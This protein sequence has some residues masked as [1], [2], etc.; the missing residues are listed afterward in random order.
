[1]AETKAVCGG[2]LIGEGLKM[3]GKVLSATG[4]GGEVVEFNV[5]WD[6]VTLY[7]DKSAYLLYI[8]NSEIED[9]KQSFT[10]NKTVVLI[11]E[12]GTKMVVDYMYADD[13]FTEIH[14]GNL[15]FETPSYFTSK[16]IDANGLYC[17]CPNPNF[18]Y[19]YNITANAQNEIT[20]TNDLR[21]FLAFCNDM[22]NYKVCVT[23]FGNDVEAFLIN[24]RSTLNGTHHEPLTFIG[25]GNQTGDEAV[26]YVFKEITPT[27]IKGY[28]T[29]LTAM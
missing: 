2:F 14:C 27:L 1:M 21:D 20:I 23:T 26:L 28:K 4:G 17:Y 13:D 7:N 18:S 19:V 22:V 16:I 29:T 9:I 12:D 10:Q 24:D 3:E 15:I 11:D 6:N 5:F 8:P 25:S